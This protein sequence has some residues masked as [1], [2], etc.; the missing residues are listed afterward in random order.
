MKA[1]FAEHD[2]GPLVVHAP[3]YINLASSDNSKRAFSIEILAE[4]LHRAQVLGAPYVVAHM[5]HARKDE[6]QDSEARC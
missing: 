1:I 3:Y 4:D 2:I 6:E 5:G